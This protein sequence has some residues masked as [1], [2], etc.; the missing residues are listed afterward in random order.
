MTWGWISPVLKGA[1]R[2]DLGEADQGVHQSQLPRIVELEA[3]D[4]PAGRGVGRLGEML[5]LSAIDKSIG[6]AR[7]LPLDY[8]AQ[9][10]FRRRHPSPTQALA[11]RC[12]RKA[13]SRSCP[14]RRYRLPARGYSVCLI[15]L[16][17]V[18]AGRFST[19]LF[20]LA[21]T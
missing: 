21:N 19:A 7:P 12:G 8:S 18:D 6:S 17:L 4:A 20:V 5:E 3:G 10:R 16:K 1:G 14:A 13:L 9:P 11:P 2:R 15:F